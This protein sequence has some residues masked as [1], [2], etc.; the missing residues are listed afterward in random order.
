MLTRCR[1]DFIHKTRSLNPYAQNSILILMW[2]LTPP[3]L[4]RTN[5]MKRI[6]LFTVIAILP[7][8]AACH[9]I[10]GAGEDVTAVGKG[11]ES[12]ASN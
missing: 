10:Q 4:R 12:A 9:T 5:D 1:H 3:N 7:I 6:A 8:L 11:M 2:H